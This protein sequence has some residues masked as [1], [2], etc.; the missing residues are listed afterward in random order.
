[1][2]DGLA[3]DKTP[4]DQIDEETEAPKAV[5]FDD[6]AR[7]AR[8]EG[9]DN[10]AG[11]AAVEGEGTMTPEIVVTNVNAGMQTRSKTRLASASSLPVTSQ[12]DKTAQ[13]HAWAETNPLL[14]APGSAA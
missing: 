1:M 11:S 14:A 3:G 5:R 6:V 13:I 7:I 10:V 9:D 12:P 2:N 8:F 4:L